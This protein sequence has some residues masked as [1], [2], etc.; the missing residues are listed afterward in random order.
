MEMLGAITGLIGAGLQAQAQHDQLMFQY[1]KFN[2]EKQRADKQDRFAAA[3]RSDQYGNKTSYDE[4]LNEWGVKLTPTQQK[5][6]QGGEKE[7]LLQLTEDAPAA[8]KIK[9]AVQARAAQAKEPFLKASLGYQFDQPK[10]ESRIRSELTGLM[11]QN[12]MQKTKAEQ[13]LIMR[14]AAR[15]GKGADASKIIQS[16]EVIV[17]LL[18]K[19]P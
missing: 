4:L 14:Q 2:W 11:A 6:M 10:G 7:Q 5:L 13:A 8:R 18:L 3:S 9:R 12:E 19:S 1:A 17:P 15:L 16:A